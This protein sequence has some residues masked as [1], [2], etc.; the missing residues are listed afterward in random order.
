MPAHRKLADL[1]GS[2]PLVQRTNTFNCVLR[3]F[4]LCHSQNPDICK[5]QILP[6][7]NL[8]AFFQLMCGRITPYDKLGASTCLRGYQAKVLYDQ[9]TMKTAQSLHEVNASE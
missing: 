1:A 9:N 7:R 6:S 3:G 4:A 5:C 2:L 8:F